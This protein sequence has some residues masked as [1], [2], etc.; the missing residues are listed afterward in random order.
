MSIIGVGNLLSPQPIKFFLS[1]LGRLSLRFFWLK[2][3]LKIRSFL[4]R[5]ARL[6]VALEKH[7]LFGCGC[8]LSRADETYEFDIVTTGMDAPLPL[9]RLEP[10]PRH[11]FAPL[12]PLDTDNCPP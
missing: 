8:A 10:E 2:S 9:V 12:A 4:N 5:I 6:Y 1:S 7:E 3:R 11:C